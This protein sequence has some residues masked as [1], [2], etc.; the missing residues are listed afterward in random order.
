LMSRTGRGRGEARGVGC[1]SSAGEKA[2]RQCQCALAGLASHCPPPRYGSG[3]ITIR[4]Q[5]GED[6]V[7][8]GDGRVRTGLIRGV[9]IRITAT[10]R[11]R[12][13]D[14]RLLGI[15]EWRLP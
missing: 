2:P 8:K 3:G 14:A 15:V 13:N 10:R 11:D 12:S 7:G 9:V 1:C 4:R 5:R 6:R